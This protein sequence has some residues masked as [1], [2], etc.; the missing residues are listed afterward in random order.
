MSTKPVPNTQWRNSMYNFRF[1]EKKAAIGFTY[2]DSTPAPPPPPEEE[3]AAGDDDE[4]GS[5]FSDDEVDLDAVFD[6]DKLTTEQTEALNLC[7]TEYG[8]MGT[9]FFEWVN[10]KHILFA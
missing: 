9:D 8:M 7:G 1:A 3:E 2:E 10:F 4:D 5:D 6:I